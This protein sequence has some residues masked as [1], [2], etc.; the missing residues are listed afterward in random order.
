MKIKI[1]EEVELPDGMFCDWNLC[2][3]STHLLDALDNPNCLPCA[4]FNSP[5]YRN[6]DTG[7]WVRCNEC[8]LAHLEALR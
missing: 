8:V 1:Q 6:R 2:G 5:I 3:N 7:R 4:K